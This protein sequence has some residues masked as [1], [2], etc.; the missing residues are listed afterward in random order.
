MLLYDLRVSKYL[1]PYYSL[2]INSFSAIM[3]LDLGHMRQYWE[4]SCV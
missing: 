2:N 1:E 4:M 3:Y